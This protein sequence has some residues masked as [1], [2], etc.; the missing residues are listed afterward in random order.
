MR[1]SV[2]YSK[3]TKLNLIIFESISNLF[4]KYSQLEWELKHQGK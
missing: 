2:K 3:I 4:L 1:L